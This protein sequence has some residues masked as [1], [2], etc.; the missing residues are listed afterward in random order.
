[1]HKHHSERAHVVLRVVVN[2][3]VINSTHMH[4]QLR[5]YYLQRNQLMGCYCFHKHSLTVGN[6]LHPYHN[7]TVQRM[8]LT[9]SA[10]NCTYNTLIQ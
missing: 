9:I 2:L 4:L 5:L 7:K 8:C 6:V 1:M 3:A 10:S